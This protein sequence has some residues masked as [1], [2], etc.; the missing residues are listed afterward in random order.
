MLNLFQQQYQHTGLVRG[1]TGV[2]TSPAFNKVT[3][4]F[5]ARTT[6]NSHTNQLNILYQTSFYLRRVT[7]YYCH[8]STGKKK[9]LCPTELI[10]PVVIVAFAFS[11]A[12]VYKFLPAPALISAVLE[13]SAHYSS[14]FSLKSFSFQINHFSKISNSLIDTF[15]KIFFKK[16]IFYL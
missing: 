5:S 15:L 10:F 1:L 2:G 4:T 13:S 9:F 14:Y 6:V 7:C 3:V 12:P 16:R 11:T 8:P